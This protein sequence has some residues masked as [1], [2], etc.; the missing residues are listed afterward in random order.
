MTFFILIFHPTDDFWDNIC[1]YLEKRINGDLEEKQILIMEK[2]VGITRK[3]SEND[4][5]YI[6]ANSY[7]NVIFVL[8]NKMYCNGRHL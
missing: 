2:V 6:Y 7:R 8:V 1:F 4:E 5:G 3:V